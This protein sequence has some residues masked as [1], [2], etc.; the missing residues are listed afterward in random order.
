MDK[1][2]IKAQVGDR[3]KRLLEKGYSSVDDLRSTIAQSFELGCDPV[4]LG[5]CYK[6]EEEELFIMDFD[7]L[8]AAVQAASA[9]GTTL[10]IKAIQD[11][12]EP[13]VGTPI[14]PCPTLTTT[15]SV[16][17][18]E[19]EPMIEEEPQF[20][21]NLMEELKQ[22][23][24][25]IEKDLGPNKE[26][27]SDSSDSEEEEK[28]PQEAPTEQNKP[29]QKEKKNFR[30]FRFAEV[31]SEVEDAINNSEDKVT[32]KDLAH[33]FKKATEGTKLEQMFRN[34]A[35]QMKHKGHCKKGPKKM[36]KFFERMMNK[37]G[38][39]E[40]KFSKKCQKP[41]DN[42]RKRT[43]E[44]VVGDKPVHHGI[45][46]DGC[47]TNNIAGFRY[48]CAECPDYDLCEGC[49][50][51]DVHSHHTFL[52]VKTHQHI[53]VM[54]SYRTDGM[55]Q[56][57]RPQ[58]FSARG[59]RPEADHPFFGHPHGP[60]HHG[61]GLWGG[62]R[63]GG[64]HHW[65]RGHRAG[66]QDNHEGPHHGMKRMM[67]EF[68]KNMMGVPSDEEGSTDEEKRQRKEDN[69]LRRPKLLVKP[70]ATVQG[71]PG[72]ISIIDLTVQNMTRWPCPLR[73]IQKTEG[74]DAIAFEA[75]DIDAKLKY[76]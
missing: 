4:T 17:I 35:R 20:D 30:K 49:E 56:E 1:I 5:L 15:Q 57:P 58:G 26:F 23:I 11:Y 42:D 13:A 63:R 43:A 14:E 6:D 67:K 32:R 40:E 76:C 65:G 18:V 61:R 37:F 8:K 62:P 21:N 46:C 66:G 69:L 31:F 72:E 38:R 60:P 2:S 47:S 52:K 45:T 64:P 28:V 48:K 12:H 51:K 24:C 68:M 36:H 25:E 53:D 50:A 16:E 7:D 9:K 22:S 19:A 74:S 75:L 59:P 73:S 70:E 41:K 39:C 71:N 3:I 34:V 44:E 54:E 55:P 29:E 33:A 10:K 27:D